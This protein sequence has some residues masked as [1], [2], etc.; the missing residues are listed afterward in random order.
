MPHYIVHRVNSIEKLQTIPRTFGVEVDVR[1]FH[2]ELVVAHD[3]F[4]R[5]DP[6]EEWLKSFMHGT[7]IVN[8]KEEGLE[9]TVL[10]LLETHGINDFFFLDQS[11]PFLLKFSSKSLFRS[12]IRFSEYE[13]IQL[14]QNFKNV[15]SWV[16]IDC[17]EKFPIDPHTVDLLLS[18][19]LKTCLV[20]PE[21]QG[22]T[23]Q[24]Q[25]KMSVELL[26]HVNFQ[27]DAICTKTPEVWEECFKNISR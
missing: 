21:L 10:L 11:I 1:L 13:P 4:Q 17:F 27:P 15:V 26:A 25:I 16:W 23:S 20:S 24:D 18:L 5:G 3:P 7:L 12:A 14:V 6:F 9:S 22:R 2:G 19:G 8:L